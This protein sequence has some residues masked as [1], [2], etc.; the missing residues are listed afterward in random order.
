MAPDTIE[1]IS[2]L[3][4]PALLRQQCYVDGNW[5][6]AD[7]G[8]TH[9]V[10]NPATGRAIG[11]VP[12]FLREETRRA[13]EAAERAWPAWRAK[14]AK[15][16]SVILRKWNDLMLANVDDLALIL[17]TEQ[18]KPLA[19]SKGE[20]TIG[21]AYI[22]WFAEE[23]KRVYGDVIPTIGNDR[24]LVVT[25]Q[26]IGVCGAI[27]PW[28]FPCSMITRK[29]SP[30]LAAG[31]TVVLKPANETPLT[32]LALVALAEKAG[33]P[34]GVFNILTGNSSAIGKVLCE[35]PAVRFVGF[36]GSTAVGKILYQQA[37]VGV[38]KLG[39][40]LGGNAPFVVF[41]DADID[42][43]VD[44]AMVSKYR[45]MGQTCVCANRIYAQ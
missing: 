30:A 44:G 23:A 7:S 32:A 10:A 39:L 22:E 4:D 8:A 3:H 20:V 24:R 33:V 14:P 37:S 15:E 31:C 27:T 43:A 41:D 26:P 38:K 12:V 29:V 40:E 5:T 2:T 19:E 25:K 16:R 6:D 11:T 21:A 9:A 34:K 36:T 28:N 45:N 17:T 1:R 18:G 35:H 42:A 13:I